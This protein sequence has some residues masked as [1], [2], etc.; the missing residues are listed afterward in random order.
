MS[1]YISREYIM[2]KLQ[3]YIANSYKG[4]QK[5]EWMDGV[6]PVVINSTAHDMLCVVRSIVENAPAADVRP[7]VRGEWIP[8][9]ERLRSWK[10]GFEDVTTGYKCSVCGREERFMEPFCNCGADMR[11]GGGKDERA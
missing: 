1:D 8:I 9:T 11:L 6:R 4:E 3:T 7:V 10:H 5:I 2:A